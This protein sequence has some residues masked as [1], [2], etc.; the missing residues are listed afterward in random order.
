MS[1]GRYHQLFATGGLVA[2]GGPLRTFELAG[3]DGRFE[4][5][6]AQID[7]DCVVVRSASVASPAAARYGWSNYPRDCNLFNAAGLPAAPFRTHR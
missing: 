2:R 4:P 3:S 1:E 6:E 7:G 5:A